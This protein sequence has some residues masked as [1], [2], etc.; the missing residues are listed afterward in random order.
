M[1]APSFSYRTTL[2]MQSARTRLLLASAIVAI[3]ILL[4]SWAIS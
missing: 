3:L 4:T 2:L 1:S